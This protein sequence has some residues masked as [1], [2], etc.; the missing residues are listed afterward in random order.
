[1]ILRIVIDWRVLFW[2]DSGHNFLSENWGIRS[3]QIGDLKKHR[4]RGDFFLTNREVSKN[5]S[6]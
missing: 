5:S 6:C 3:N 4:R 2:E 1:M